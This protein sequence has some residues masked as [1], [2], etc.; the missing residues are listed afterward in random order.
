MN[1]RDQ[2]AKESFIKYMEEHPE[3]RFWQAVRNWGC[4]GQWGSILKA[5]LDED[6]KIKQFQDTFYEEGDK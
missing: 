2:K 3:E 6:G 5:D 1:I 4:S